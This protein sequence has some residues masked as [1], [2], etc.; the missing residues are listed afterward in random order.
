MLKKY[1]QLLLVVIFT[2]AFLIT[3]QKSSAQINGY[4]S[5]GID[6]NY[7]GNYQGQWG[8]GYYGGVQGCNQNW[9]QGSGAIN[10]S[11]EELE[12][13]KNIQSAKSNLEKE[14]LEKKRADSEMEFAKKKLE[15][16]FDSEILDFLIDVHM[17]K[18]NLCSNYKLMASVPA[19]ATAGIT[20]CSIVDANG[21]EIQSSDATV[22]GGKDEIPAKLQGKWINSTGTGYCTASSLSKAGDVSS[23]ICSDATLR[24]EDSPKYRSYSSNE[25]GKSLSNYKKFKLK[26]EKSQARIEMLEDEIRERA[27]AI[28]DAKERAALERKYRQANTSETDCPE[29]D[30]AARGNTY[31]KPK[32]DWVSIL[33]QV[34]VG[35]GLGVLGKQYDDRNAE[36]NA[37]LGYPPQ[38]GY[39]TAVSMGLPF[40][41]GGVY[42]AINGTS[43]Q[44]GFG[45][46]GGMNGTGGVYGAGNGMNGPF[47]GAG[48]VYGP[49]GNANG[50]AF[51][52]P[53]GMYGTPWGGGMYN[54]GYG[55]GGSIAGPWGGFP[56]GGTN[57]GFAVNGMIN[58]GW[59]LNGGAG[60][61]YAMGGMPMGGGF[62]MGGSQ[63]VTCFMPPCPGGMGGGGFAQ[64]GY[65]AGGGF[66]MGGAP[67]GGMPMGGYVASG[68]GIFNGGYAQGGY[69][70]GGGYQMGGFQAGGFQMGGAPIGGMPMGGY[71][72]SGGG[73]FNSGYA[74]GG[75]A[76]GGGYQMGG[77]A[78]GGMGY[79]MMAM[80]NGGL[81]MGGYQAGGYQM[82]AVASG[83]GITNGGYMVNAG[84]VTNGQYQLQMMQ[85]QQQMQQQQMQQQMQYQQAQMQQ[86]MQAYQRQMAVQQQAAQV[87]QEIASLQVRLQMLY[88]GSY[89]SNSTFNTGG[90]PTTTI[91]GGNNGQVV[92][93]Q[94]NA[95]AFPQGNVNPGSGSQITVPNGR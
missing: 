81:A 77:Y 57:A 86:Q 21:K 33:G 79:P 75:Y 6:A 93:P 67:M 70:A 58:G 14:K 87:Q 84:A 90:I 12:E 4:A 91:P 61:G 35:L 38:Q 94:G 62:Q 69:A 59:M 82:G 32:R 64:G 95:N 53:Q 8:S 55:A 23:K 34:G 65:A 68:G 85:M 5:A 2:F 31:T 52:Y 17:D 7:S 20:T 11:D 92:Y 40:V 22:C 47:G 72:A 37:Q 43:G 89:T 3:G 48:G 60:G 24:P 39:P 63:M 25:C 1:F 9:Q 78:A 51:G 56:G 73:I 45:C 30:A 29:C 13:R 66:Q 42:G 28:A 80:A 83:N 49:Y 15:R 16:V 27:Y 88:S 41:L 71:V 26:S 46:A 36:Y 54:P 44:G 18:M 76:A 10:V 50:G 74:Q 19:N